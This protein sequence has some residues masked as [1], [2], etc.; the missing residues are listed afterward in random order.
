[1]SGVAGNLQLLAQCVI[2]GR[3]EEAE[4][5]LPFAS[6]C[7]FTSEAA[8]WTALHLA[9][10]LGRLR[11]LRVFLRFICNTGRQD[12]QPDGA[13]LGVD[14]RDRQSCTP[15]HRA[16]RAGRLDAARMLLSAGARLDVA[17]ADGKIPVVAAASRGHAELVGLLLS[18]KQ[19]TAACAR[20]ALAEALGVAQCWKTAQEVLRLCP[21]A[22]HDGTAATTALL[23]VCRA[24][25]AESPIRMVKLLCKM[26]ADFDAVDEFG[27][28]P[29]H[30]ASKCGWV[31]V[32]SLLLGNCKTSIGNRL[33]VLARTPLTICCRFAGRA[34]RSL[35]VR[36]MLRHG[37]NPNSSQKN[38][39]TSP[40]TMSATRA[41]VDIAKALIDAGAQMWLEA[42]RSERREMQAILAA[43]RFKSRAHIM[44]FAKRSK[45]IGSW[46]DSEGFGLFHAA[47]ES[48]D[49]AIMKLVERL[50]ANPRHV[51]KDGRSAVHYFVMGYD[52]HEVTS[53][54]GRLC[55]DA[56]GYLV[57]TCGLNPDQEM[58]QSGLTPLH[59]NRIAS[60][61]SAL[62][63]HGATVDS[64][65]A[66]SMYRFGRRNRTRGHPS[67]QLPSLT[68]ICQISMSHASS[69]A[70]L[71]CVQE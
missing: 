68:C 55:D 10:Y 50:G 47:A 42:K 39:V 53:V 17:D 14:F 63:K 51:S 33:D 7:A 46:S 8:Q 1:M 35:L 16:A 62:I 60:I 20:D 69:I 40:L 44:L 61:A 12:E 32:A 11:V 36:L 67:I 31:D 26:G 22:A 66:N 15:L 9:A 49:V 2:E 19:T 57:D 5:L 27:N 59:I 70:C 24:C 64:R 71:M 29:L 41:H 21:F 13:R 18:R 28:T 43:V 52:M 4:A 3:H 45:S 34:K 6:P 30:F 38:C 65:C 23:N 56:V 48:G 54:H 25:P 58:E 37:A